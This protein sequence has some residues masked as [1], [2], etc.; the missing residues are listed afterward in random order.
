MAETVHPTQAELRKQIK[1]KPARM[2]KGGETIVEPCG[3]ID[4]PLVDELMTEG[5]SDV[6]EEK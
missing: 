2:G 3:E 4:A 1:R 5:E 6:A